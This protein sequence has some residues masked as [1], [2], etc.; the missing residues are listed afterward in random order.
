MAGKTKAETVAHLHAFLEEEIVKIVLSALIIVSV[1][2]ESV[3]PAGIAGPMFLVFFFL[4]GF[5]FSVRV[6]KFVPDFRANRAGYFE[7]ALLLFD[8]VATLSFLPVEWVYP[9]AKGL[10]ILRLFRLT[11]MFLLLRYWGPVAKEIW[12]ILMKRRYQLLFAASVVLILSFVAGVLLANFSTGFDYND[13]GSITGEDRGFFTILWWSF[14]QVQ[15]PGNL[16][17]EPR[18]GIIFALSSLLTVGGLFIVS[19]LIGIGTTVVEELVKSSRSRPIGMKEHSAILNISRSSHLLL[20]ELQNYYLKH[21][22]KSRI[23]VLG[24]T[25]AR[26]DY[27]FLPELRRVRYRWGHPSE[28]QDLK[29]VDCERASR[30]ILLGDVEEPGS[31]AQVISQVLS[32]RQLN[33]KGRI[34]AEIHQ[35]TNLNAAAEAGGRGTVPIPVGKFSGLFL[36]NIVLFPGIEDVYRELLTSTGQEIY[37][38]IFGEREFPVLPAGYETPPFETL[39]TAAY[40]R[41]GIILLG[42]FG[43]PPEDGAPW[44]AGHH[45]V[46]NPGASVRFGA[47]LRGVIGVSH[48]FED[49]GDFARDLTEGRVTEAQGRPTDDAFPTFMLCPESFGLE[50]VLI[51]NWRDSLVDFLEQLALFLKNI[52]IFVMVKDEAE[53]K[54]V[55]EACLAHSLRAAAGRE[56]RG[57]G[58]KRLKTGLVYKFKKRGQPNVP[59]RTVVGDPSDERELI[60]KR[61]GGFRLKDID[62][63][64][65]TPE[66]DGSEDPDAKTAVGMLK[67]WNLQRTR[68]G[69]LKKSFRVIGEISDPDK[70]DLLDRRAETANLNA[71]RCPQFTILSRERIRNHFLAQ[72]IFVPGIASIYH[73]LLSETG[74]EICRL[75]PDWKGAD[76]DRIVEFP[77]LLYTLYRRDGVTLFGVEIFDEETETRRLV[78]NPRRHER[79][80]RFRLGD[81][82]AILCVG[83]TENFERK[84]KRCLYCIRARKSRR[85]PAEK[86]LTEG[87]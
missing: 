79:G 65:Y 69:E 13:D 56:E 17:R 23:A 39:F 7:G 16:V 83:D 61:I 77:D 62:T 43:P 25:E 1:L 31:D 71:H 37:T 74:Q 15:D 85:K 64:V 45:P 51:C 50:K 18:G 34:L 24:P 76:P 73:Q 80:F 40:E 29:K 75:L 78:L 3:L 4:F 66:R 41:Y 38:V 47:D 20:T 67:L 87:E 57:G 22:R 86:P 10:K 32:A 8:L 5:E 26:P 27:L 49:L 52:E 33:P 2:P 60:D 14:R 70:G 82:I 21:V 35:E 28:V 53:A 59:V 48:V 12:I 44:K 19:F 36:T 54:G 72:A 81:L 84:G 55:E 46:L 11:R 58:F 68:P 30:I 63:V 42:V 6:A 9:P